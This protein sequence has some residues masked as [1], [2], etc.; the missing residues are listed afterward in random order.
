MLDVLRKFFCDQMATG[1]AGGD[2]G[3]S[4]TMV[5]LGAEFQGKYLVRDDRK[6]GLR[7]MDQWGNDPV[8]GQP[9]GSVTIETLT[10]PS[11]LLWAMWFGGKP[12]K[13]ECLPFLR[14]EVLLP[15]YQSGEFYG[16]RGKNWTGSF[17]T[18]NFLYSNTWTGDFSRFSGEERIVGRETELLEDGRT[19]VRVPM[20]GHRYWGGSF[21]FL[22]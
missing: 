2:D 5:I 4:A 13:K 20:G 18:D 3:N 22:R 8:T 7:L 9:T 16:G 1:W 14:E 19:S 17:G 15:V 21:S 10:R 12:Y 6:L 11:L